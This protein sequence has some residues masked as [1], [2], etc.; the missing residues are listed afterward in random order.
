V[1]ERRV[2]TAD[3]GTFLKAPAGGGI[4]NDAAIVSA[5]ADAMTQF[6]ARIASAIQALPP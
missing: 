1:V 4:S 6:A 3:R 2:L 5:M